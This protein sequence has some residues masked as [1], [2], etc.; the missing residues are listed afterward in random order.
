MNY[1]LSVHIGNKI[2][3]N[4][5]T[6][7]VLILA[8]IISLPTNRQGCSVCVRARVFVCVCDASTLDV[9]QPH[10]AVCSCN[11]Q[12]SFTSLSPQIQP[13]PTSPLLL[14]IFLSGRPAPLR[15]HAQHFLP[16]SD[17]C[18]KALLQRCACEPCR[19]SSFLRFL[20]IPIILRLN[21]LS[22]GESG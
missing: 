13:Q 14:I 15:T 9:S 1:I 3:G 11:S 6:L 16:V 10:Q 19:T 4:R 5:Y 20:T 18:G 22:E 2:C 8:D 7:A 21:D 17:N 12:R